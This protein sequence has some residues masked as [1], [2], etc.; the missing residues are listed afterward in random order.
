M[1]HFNET[2]A[3]QLDF[4][5]GRIA[6][7]LDRL[8]RAQH[9]NEEIDWLISRIMPAIAQVQGSELLPMTVFRTEAQANAIWEKVAIELDE[10]GAGPVNART[11]V[12]AI[13]EELALNAAQHSFSESNCHAIVEMDVQR[14]PS[15]SVQTGDGILYVVGISDGGIGIPNSL[16][17]NPIYTHITSDREAILR[18]IE[19]DVSGTMEQRGAGLYHVVDRVRAY[20]GTLLIVSGSGFLISLKGGAPSVGEL[21]DDGGIFHQ[22]TVVVASVPVPA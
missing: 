5:L 8:L 4:E 13:F 22:G 14:S 11:E 19:M 17:K 12:D 16:R 9:L 2:F 6:A 15:T 1:D 20:H 3:G 21:S 7:C 18:A 10:R